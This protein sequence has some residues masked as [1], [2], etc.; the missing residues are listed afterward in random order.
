[1]GMWKKK[2]STS[3]LAILANWMEILSFLR[4]HSL[5]TPRTPFWRSVRMRSASSS[6]AM[7]LDTVEIGMFSRWE[8]SSTFMLRS[9]SRSR[10]RSRS[11]LDRLDREALS[12]HED[13][14]NGYQKVIETYRDRMIIIDASRDVDAVI[15]D[16]Y[17]AVKEII[18]G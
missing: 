4:L 8:S 6:T 5:E 2:L 3:R 18:D 13:V 17:N 15:E 1:M 12:F 9:S 11:S 10:I 14:Y 16:A 7:L